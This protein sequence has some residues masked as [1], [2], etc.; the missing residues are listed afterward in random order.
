MMVS[1]IIYFITMNVKAFFSAINA[2]PTIDDLECT[3]SCSDS[4]EDI[5]FPAKPTRASMLA[6]KSTVV[7]AA[8]C[9]QHLSPRSL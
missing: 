6:S 4:D 3:E 7:L 2:T 5:V 9:E 8:S 1:V